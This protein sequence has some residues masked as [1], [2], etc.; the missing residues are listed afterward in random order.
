MAVKTVY[1][2]K[3]MR[4]EL[5]ED[6]TA[7]LWLDHGTASV[8]KFDKKLLEELTQAVEKIHA[9]PNISGMILASAK[10]VFVVGADITEFK[11]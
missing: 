5:E 8:N 6:G 1:S 7:T 11:G 4:C 3:H 2:G 10:D 9:T